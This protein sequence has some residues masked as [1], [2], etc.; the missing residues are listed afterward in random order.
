MNPA[1]RLAEAEKQLRIVADEFDDSTK[2]LVVSNVDNAR[3]AVEEAREHLP[4][5]EDE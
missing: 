1:T 3:I 4:G 5:G 2:F